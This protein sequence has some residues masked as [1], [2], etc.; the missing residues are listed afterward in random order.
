MGHSDPESLSCSSP[1]TSAQARCG[2]VYLH[3]L[4]LVLHCCRLAWF[5]LR[6]I[7]GGLR[8]TGTPDYKMQV[9][10]GTRTESES[11]VQTDALPEPRSK[12]V[13]KGEASV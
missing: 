2:V 7:C 11:E 4:P 12:A 5:D 9:D 13:S 3:S 1:P 10:S 8:D 6:L